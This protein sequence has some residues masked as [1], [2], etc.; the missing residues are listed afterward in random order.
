MAGIRLADLPQELST[1]QAVEAAYGGDLDNLRERLQ[2]RLSVLVECDKALTQQLYLALRDRLK[3]VGLQC[4]LVGGQPRR[5]ASSAPASEAEP[6]RGA[7]LVAEPSYLQSFLQNLRVALEESIG[8]DDQ[9]IVLPHLD[10]LTT[11][12]RSGLT[13]SAKEAL[14]WIL[15]VPDALLLGFRD[16]SFELPKPVEDLFAAR[17]PVIGLRREAIG[18]L[19]L[20]REARKLAVDELQ[21]YRLY[22][23]VSGLNAVR[24]R[25]VLRRFDSA[26]DFDP[27]RPETVQQIY[28]ELRE[29]TL[30]AS[31]EVPQVD[32]WRD[33]GGYDSIKQQLEDDLL[34]LLRRR[35]EVTAPHLAEQIESVIPRGLIFHGPPGTGKTFFAKALATALDASI[36]IVSGPELKERWVGA[37]EENLR[38]VFQQA[39]K[40]APSI[41]VFDELDSLAARRGMYYGSGVEH[42]L[43]NQLLTE[44]DG[45]RG[46]ELVF[47]VGTTNFV[48]SLDPALLRPGRFELQIEIP[49]PDDADRRAI[50]QL[51]R[52][53][54]ALDLPDEVLEYAVERTADV[55]DPTSGLRYTGDHLQAACRA[56]KRQELRTGPFRATR[57][58]IDAALQRRP[59]GTLVVSESELR[60]VAY[61]EVGHAVCAHYLPR[62]PGVRKIS[63]RPGEINLPA[64]GV[65]LQKAREN[66]HLV[67]REELLDHIAVSLGG[68]L[69]EE[70]VLGAVSNGAQMDLQQATHLARLMVEELGM[71]ERAGNQAYRSPDATGGERWPV[72]E[73]VAARL[74][75]DTHALL[76][77]AESRAR[78][79]I[80]RHRERIERLVTLLLAETTLDEERLEQ[81]W[82]AGAPT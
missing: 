71:G 43:V 4:V 64:L 12:T 13:D 65:M 15:E 8:R 44:M 1:A 51:Y 22:K 68:R 10:L 46:D 63:L 3:A 26:P 80:N 57:Q 58:D 55:A 60:T 48:S 29:L 52:G 11:T 54:F 28:R 49:Y 75:E 74:D 19:L 81:F 61:H 41:I 59:Y 82:E 50:W 2:A 70:L 37:S 67:T 72:G 21:P 38:R 25:Q 6:G 16:P 9:V 62:V 33:I 77:A 17:M 24:L 42:G 76:Q 36:S 35:D 23:Y 18:R 40:A 14:A 34:A 66:K 78:Q 20:R 31:F 32:L 45:F 79:V 30:L 7:P 56:L 53:K 39:R 47:V 73:A 27:A 69:A 5:R